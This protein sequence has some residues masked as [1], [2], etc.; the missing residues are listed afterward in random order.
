M[1]SKF[2]KEK[3]FLDIVEFEMKASKSF[4]GKWHVI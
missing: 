1:F 3:E 2:E 4:T